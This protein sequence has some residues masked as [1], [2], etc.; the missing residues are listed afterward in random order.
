MTSYTAIANGDIDQDSPVTQPLVTALRDN[1]IAIGEADSS[2]PAGLLPTVLLGTL[3]TTSGTTVT[4]SGLTLTPY[5]SLLIAVNGVSTVAS[6]SGT[7]TFTIAGCT[8]FTVSAPALVA[9]GGLCII[10]LASS[11]GTSSIAESSGA[12][13]SA[14]TA[15]SLVLRTSLTTASTSISV[16][17]DLTFDAG[18]VLVYG[19]K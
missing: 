13:P 14:A 18:S 7:R 17:A 15:T 6:V 12:A 10:D 5:K 4:L 19:V 2:V 8:V 9:L 11:V 3:T 16:T 1:P